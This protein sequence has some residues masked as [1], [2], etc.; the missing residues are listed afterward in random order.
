MIKVESIVPILEVDGKE[1]SSMNA[2]QP[3]LKVSSHWRRNTVVVLDIGDGKTIAVQSA[4]LVAAT[5]NATNRGL[6]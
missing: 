1:T 5:T 3:T 6:R 4:D 2:N